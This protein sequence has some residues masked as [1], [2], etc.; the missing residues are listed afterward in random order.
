[1]N[2]S[3]QDDVERLMLGTQPRLGKAVSLLLPTNFMTRSLL[4]DN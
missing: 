1:M 3:D 4:V 2:V